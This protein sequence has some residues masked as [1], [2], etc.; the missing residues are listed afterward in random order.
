[1][2]ASLPPLFMAKAQVF[3]DLVGKGR[4][5]DRHLYGYAQRNLGIS[6]AEADKIVNAL[7]ADGRLQ[8]ETSRD[9]I[10]LRR[11]VQ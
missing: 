2:S 10:L 7:Q 11:V 6:R 9:G 5:F 8:I 4:F 1:M 3:L